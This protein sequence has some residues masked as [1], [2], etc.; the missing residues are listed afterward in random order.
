[1]FYYQQTRNTI[2]TMAKVLVTFFSL[3]LADVDVCDLNTF[4]A[5]WARLFFTLIDPPFF[6]AVKTA[7]P[8]LAIK[9]VLFDT[10]K[11]WFA[12]TMDILGIV[13]LLLLDIWWLLWWDEGWLGWWKPVSL[14]SMRSKSVEVAANMAVAWEAARPFWLLTTSMSTR[15]VEDCDC[16]AT[17]ATG[18]S[19][20]AVLPAVWASTALE[21]DLFLSANMPAEIRLIFSFDV[22]GDVDLRRFPP[23]TV[24]AS[25]AWCFSILTAVL[26]DKLRFAWLGEWLVGASFAVCGLRLAPFRAICCFVF[27]WFDFFAR[28]LISYFLKRFHLN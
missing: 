27:E 11:L 14:T 22:G 17:E 2:K 8:A 15:S 9:L 23:A 3:L 21:A 12:P 28:A 5:F 6:L 19:I 13:L 20:V 10:D 26:A 18:P 4:I 24:V 25:D 16:M 1:M 7:K